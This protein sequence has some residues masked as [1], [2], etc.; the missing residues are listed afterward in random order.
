[1]QRSLS[2]ADIWRMSPRRLGFIIRAVYDQ[3]ATAENLTKWKLSQGRSCGMCGEPQTLKHVIS[4]CREALG[5][6][7][8][9]WR[10][11][12]VLKEIVKVFDTAKCDA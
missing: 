6:G 10:H 9:T 8:Y 1:M 7:R 5:S 2:W 12:E 3:L 4:S 11:N